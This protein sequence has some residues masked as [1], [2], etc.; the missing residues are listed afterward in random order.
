MPDY[1]K[2]EENATRRQGKALKKAA[3]GKG[4]AKAP[5]GDDECD[6]EG[7]AWNPE[8]DVDEG[9]EENKV[10]TEAISA[11]VLNSFIHEEHYSSSEL[12]LKWLARLGSWSEEQIS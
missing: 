9:Y 6:P 4:K 3:K 12:R 10:A 2:E 1:E 7:P 5:T 8:N 11:R